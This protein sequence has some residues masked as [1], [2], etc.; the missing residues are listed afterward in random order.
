MAVAME[1]DLRGGPRMFSTMHGEKGLSESH[2]SLTNADTAL[3]T[4]VNKHGARKFWAAVKAQ[5]L[6]PEDV[7]RNARQNEIKVNP[8]VPAPSVPQITAHRTKVWEDLRQARLREVEICLEDMK[9]DDIRRYW[10]CESGVNPISAKDLPPV[11][12]LGGMDKFNEMQQRM[13]DK[14]KEEQRR[15]AN[16]LGL[17][18][19]ME[20]KKRE[21]ADAKVAAFEKRIA[22]YKKEQAEEWK[23]RAIAGQKKQEKRKADAERASKARADWEDET[24]AA[25]WDRFSGARSR[26]NHRYSPEG[27]AAKLEAN[28][29]KRVAAFAMAT[30]MEEQMLERLEDKRLACEDRLE[31]RRIDVQARLDQQCADRQAAF[32]HKQIVIHAKTTEWVEKKLEDHTAYTAKVDASRTWYANNLKE[33]SK[34]SADLRKKTD[35]RLQVNKAK[36]K[37]QQTQS[38]EDLMIRHGMADVRREELNAMKF[39]NENDIFTFRE[40]KHH[41]F[42]EL[43]RRRNVEIGKRTDAKNQACIINLAE[44]QVKGQAQTHSLANL[45]KCRQSIGKE[46]LTL[47]DRAAEGFLKIQCE[48]DEGKVIATMNAMGFDMPK[49]PE[50]DDEEDVVEEKKAF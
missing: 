41:T 25:L 20:K 14:I 50:K 21:E 1:N 44:R 34:S 12:T 22:E 6:E 3:A 31:A 4:M 32:Q 47:M 43:T 28:K 15:K 5:G 10:K 46:S 27:L 17:D 45:R 23:Q 19:L 29:S 30:E 42:G 18:F 39:K 26:R 35:A 36:L 49:L 33:R 40:M 7:D 9:D 38:N 8:N 48:P 11:D 16:A 24:E 37:G 2:K 13:Q